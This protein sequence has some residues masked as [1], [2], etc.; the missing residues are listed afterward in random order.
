[1][2]LSGTGALISPVIKVAG[3]PPVILGK[4]REYIFNAIQAAHHIDPARTVM[5]GD[6]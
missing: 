1:M 3:K 4:P 2:F 5:I 6:K